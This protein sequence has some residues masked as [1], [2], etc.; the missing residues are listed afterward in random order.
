MTINTTL[1]KRPA[2]HQ[3]E[4]GLFPN[5]PVTQEDMDRLTMHGEYMVT[6]RS[7]KN[8]QALKFL[9]ALVH[10]TADNTDYFLDKDD[11]MR[12]L[13]IRVGY[14]KAVYDPHTRAMEVKPRSLT[15]ITDEQLRL[16]TDRMMDI[17]CSE[18]IPGMKK[19]DLRKEIE[20]MIAG[21]PEP[22]YRDAE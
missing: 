3:G 7:E 15:R 5:N 21:K 20:K 8:L 18:L 22:T 4:V 17:I 9:W 12:A 19:N 11:A 6:L 2:L 14:S 13:K 10:K 1:V 16:L